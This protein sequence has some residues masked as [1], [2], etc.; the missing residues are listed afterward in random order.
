MLIGVSWVDA[1][2]TRIVDATTLA[3]LPE[4]IHIIQQE[5]GEICGVRWLEVLER[6]PLRFS[7]GATAGRKWK[8]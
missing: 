8:S 5:R 1:G 4:T 7:R 3:K 2:G 6:S